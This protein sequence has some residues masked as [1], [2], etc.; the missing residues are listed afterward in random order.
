MLDVS[1]LPTVDG[2]QLVL[3]RRTEPEPDVQLLLD[4]LGQ[5]LPDQSPPRIRAEASEALS[6]RPSGRLSYLSIND[7]N[8]GDV[9]VT[10]VGLTAS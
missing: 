7:L 3:A 5:V 9:P 4:Q 1:R 10:E 8:P 2:R 6:S